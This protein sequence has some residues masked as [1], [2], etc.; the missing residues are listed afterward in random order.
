[1]ANTDTI[2]L[3]K[4][5]LLTEAGAVQ[6]A[7]L[8]GIPG[9]WTIQVQVGMGRRLLRPNKRKDVR[10]FKTTD[11]ALL[12]LREAGVRRASIDQ[13]GYNPAGLV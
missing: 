11:A 2:T 5:K 10:V 9:G 6:H 1:M 13:A 7:E 8:V 3:E 12:M 4:L